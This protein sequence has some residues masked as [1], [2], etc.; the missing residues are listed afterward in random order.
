MFLLLILLVL[1]IE[2]RDLHILDKPTLNYNLNYFVLSYIAQ[3]G[4]KF[5]K[6]L[7]LAFK[8]EGIHYHVYSVLFNLFEAGFYQFAHLS[9]KLCSPCSPSFNLVSFCLRVLYS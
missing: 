5:T 6:K 3:A 1:G 8:S 7:R 9:I 4:L 2:P